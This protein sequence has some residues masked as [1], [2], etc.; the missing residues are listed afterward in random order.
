[1]EIDFCNKN[2]HL[3]LEIPQI[4]IELILTGIS[5]KTI[6]A[7]YDDMRTNFS[8]VDLLWNIIDGYSPNAKNGDLEIPIA[9]L[10]YENLSKT[11]H[12]G[13]DLPTWFNYESNKSSV[14]I[15]AMEPLRTEEKPGFATLASPFA[16]HSKYIRHKLPYST[17]F[18]FIKELVKNNFNVYITDIYKL[19]CK[20]NNRKHTGEEELNH[21]I[22]KKEL[23]I[24]KPD[25]IV[26]FGKTA[27]IR[28][29]KFLN[30]YQGISAKVIHLA[31]PAAF[32]GNKHFYEEFTRLRNDNLAIK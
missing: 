27:K 3:N 24:L 4:F 30:A 29:E 22:F 23:D 1:M 31:H 10:K 32:G 20:L 12:I 15:L 9:N 13:L 21:I 19:Y 11:T 2:C 16:L 28:L 18:K 26:V 7:R 8:K 14:M 6:Q 17:T 25:Y 5:S